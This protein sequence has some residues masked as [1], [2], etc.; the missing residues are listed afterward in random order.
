MFAKKLPRQ[1]VLEKKYSCSVIVTIIKGENQIFY[2]TL[3]G[4]PSWVVR[5]YQTETEIRNPLLDM[6]SRNKNPR[7]LALRHSHIGRNCHIF[8]I[9]SQIHFRD[10]SILEKPKAW[11]QTCKC[12]SLTFC[13]SPKAGADRGEEMSQCS[14]I[15]QPYVDLRLPQRTTSVQLRLVS[16]NSTSQTVS[17]HSLRPRGCTGATGKNGVVEGN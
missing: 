16:A 15:F 10:I 13:H 2:V 14:K 3:S 7:K 11:A 9:P 5:F 6:K 1:N 12:S 4:L 8:Q 17:P